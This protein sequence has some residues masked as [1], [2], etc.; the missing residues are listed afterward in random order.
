MLGMLN[1]ESVLGAIIYARE[2]NLSNIANF[3]TG[4]P[5]TSI[6]FRISY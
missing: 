6:G 3:D 4:I 5:S 1:K 2:I